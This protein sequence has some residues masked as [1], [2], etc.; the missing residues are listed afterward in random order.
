MALLALSSLL[1]V[2]STSGLA[3]GALFIQLIAVIG[4]LFFGYAF[5]FAAGR[6][7]KPRPSLIIDGRGITD[8]VAATGAGFV[9]WEEIA[10]VGISGTGMSHFIVVIPHDAE[11]I[12]ARQPP[13]KGSVLRAN[14]SLVGS[15]VAFPGTLPMS[16]AEVLSHI[17]A[18]LKDSN[19]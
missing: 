14:M 5:V 3:H 2:L 11:A 12:L 1:F 10:G 8:N 13:F 15:P 9:T 4:I 16:L 18:R 7:F 19:A 17:Q 6:L